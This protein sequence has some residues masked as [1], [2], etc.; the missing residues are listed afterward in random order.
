MMNNFQELRDKIVL[1]HKKNLKRW[2]YNDTG[3]YLSEALVDTM[4]SGT[5][6][7][8]EVLDRKKNLVLDTKE[9]HEVVNDIKR[10]LNKLHQVFLDMSVL[11]ETQDQGLNDIEE[12][13]AKA[14]GFVS[15]G[16]NILFYA[17]Q[18]KY[19]HSISIAGAL[20]V[21]DSGNGDNIMCH[22]LHFRVVSSMIS[23]FM[24]CDTMLE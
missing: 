24:F 8:F 10:S 13:L 11:V 4:L 22:Y 7:V 17:K 6:K 2:Y 12:N 1:D 20:G 14:R 5:R 21:F 16:T 3:E 23:S 18:M 19:K 9:R 15:G